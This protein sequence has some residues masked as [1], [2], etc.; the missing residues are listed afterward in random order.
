MDRF[1]LLKSHLSYQ[2]P[3][4]NLN[5]NKESK[6]MPAQTELIQYGS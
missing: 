1:H 4:E 2:E 5:L 3:Q 6:S